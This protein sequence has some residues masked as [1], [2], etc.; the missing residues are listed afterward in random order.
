MTQQRP[1]SP[2]ALA[3]HTLSSTQVAENVVRLRPRQSSRSPQPLTVLILHQITRLRLMLGTQQARVRHHLTHRQRQILRHPD[4][5]LRP[6]RPSLQHKAFSL[7]VYNHDPRPSTH[8]LQPARLRRLHL[9]RSARQ[10]HQHLIHHPQP[11]V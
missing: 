2:R 5:A 9:H 10:P 3:R 8:H 11:H 1:R 4:T 6:L 7:T